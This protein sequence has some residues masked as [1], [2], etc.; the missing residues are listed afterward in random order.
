MAEIMSFY[1]QIHAKFPE[2]FSVD[3]RYHS[4]N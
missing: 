2:N 1:D 3:I 4:K